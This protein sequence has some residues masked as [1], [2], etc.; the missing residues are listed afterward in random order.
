MKLR[1]GIVAGVVLLLMLCAGFYLGGRSKAP[2]QPAGPT[3][4][5]AEVA[6]AQVPGD[7]T[8]KSAPVT[9]STPVEKAGLS[10]VIHPTQAVIAPGKQL[11]VEVT[12]QNTSKLPYHFGSGGTGMSS[13]LFHLRNQATGVTYTAGSNMMMNGAPLANPPT[14]RRPQPTDPPRAG[15]TPTLQPAESRQVQI[16]TYVSL[17]FYAGE[18]PTYFA[19]SAAAQELSRGH[20]G[21]PRIDGGFGFGVSAAN[22]RASPAQI[23]FPPGHYKLSISIEFPAGEQAGT[24]ADASA[25]WGGGP[26][27]SGEIDIEIAGLPTEYAPLALPADTAT[28]AISG[29][30]LGLDGQPAADTSLWIYLVMDLQNQPEPVPAGKTDS[31]GHYEITSLKPGRY[32][33]VAGHWHGPRELIR[34]GDATDFGSVQPVEVKAGQEAKLQDAIKITQPRSVGGGA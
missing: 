8:T 18:W 21:H 7:A 1:T 9:E 2:M 10:I 32:M 11:S 29:K 24:P 33:V 31:T 25:L 23:P 27:R 4:P 20:D 3:Q 19:Y 26:I 30:V 17:G 34:P 6:E 28:G 14:G 15:P 5:P 16:A 13:A 12:Y 22:I